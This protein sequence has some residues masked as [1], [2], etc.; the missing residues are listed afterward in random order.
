MITDVRIIHGPIPERLPALAGGRVGA[1]VEFR[2]IVRREE[3]G[4]AITALEYEAYEPMAEREMRRI[5][6]GLSRRRACLGAR[7]IHRIGIIPVG[8]VAVYV[9]AEAE[10]RAEAFALVTE[11]MDRLKEDVPIWKRRALVADHLTAHQTP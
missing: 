3:H 10:H 4:Q 6:A 11:F 1:W 8:E 5:L 2:G 7:V 9:G